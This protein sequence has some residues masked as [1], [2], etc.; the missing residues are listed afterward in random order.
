MK[1]KFIL[2]IIIITAFPLI[3][4]FHNGLPITHDGI[5]H[6]ARI[7]NFYNA[8]SDGI[9]IP[10]WAENL[11]WGYGHPVM[12]FLY[13]FS[14]YAASVIHFI[15]FSY[16]DSLKIIF[17]MGFIAS[18]I[19]MYLWVREQFGRHTAMLAAILYTFA[20]YRFIDLYVRGAIGEHT[21]FIFPPLV[22][23]FIYKSFYEE[24]SN[25]RGIYNFGLGIS[26]M[27]LLLSH[28]AISLMFMPLFIAYTIYL[29]SITREYK[30]L[31]FVILF[32]ILGF[33]ASGFFT[34]P[35][36]FEGKYTLRDI[37]TSNEYKTRFIDNPLKFI[38]GDWNYGI[39]GQFSVQLGLVH[40]ILMLVTFYLFIKRKLDKKISSL[41]IV[42]TSFFA[43]SILLQLSISNFMY[44]IFSTLKKFQFPWRFLSLTTFSLAI[45]SAMSISTI[46]KKN[47][48][49]FVLIIILIN[50]FITFPFW[51]AKG[52]LPKED[53]FFDQIYYG[54]TDT[55]ESSP[56]WSV[57]FMEKA[58]NN[59]SDV[60][61]G[62]TKIQEIFRSSVHHKYLINVQSNTARIRE[63][64][65]YFP[66]W[67]VNVDGQ[68]KEIEFQDPNNR[69]LITYNLEKGIRTVD[70]IF[71]ETKLRTLSNLVSVLSFLIM[72]AIVVYGF[73]GKKHV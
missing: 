46:N 49:R 61:D 41:L 13:P 3:D 65:L 27:L 29:L 12:M 70:I 15:G 31:I 53:K 68:S 18:G 40:L 56:I 11:N 2:L 21:A 69:G 34:I 36:F 23:Y 19:T 9:L 45:I 51:K 10:R 22:L 55:G 60:I 39:T 63:N 32:F 47:Q 67:S 30:K 37:V 38:Y 5:D 16:I 73:I 57:R 58:R 52:Y 1:D 4:L 14:S 33:F 24:R 26:F 44:E 54:T 72:V 43:V 42:L 64:T 8:L 25:V 20:P 71:R 50:L 48:F 17:G 35:A 66:G 28:N 7:A 62:S 59:S 6:V